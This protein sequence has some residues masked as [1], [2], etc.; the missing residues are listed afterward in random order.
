MKQNGLGNKEILSKNL[1]KYIDINKKDRSQLAKDLDVSYST[2]SDWINGNTYPRID[3]IEL[4]ARYFK[5]SKSDLIEEH[6]KD[7]YY[8]DEDTRNL[9]EELL[10][11]SQLKALFDASRGA[12]PEDLEITKNL[13]LNLKKKERKEDD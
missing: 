7:Y 12:S 11:N 2:L 1:R 3:K 6:Q 4:M 9:A 13:L 5:I 8:I 10:N